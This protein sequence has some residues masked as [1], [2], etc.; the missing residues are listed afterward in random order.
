MRNTL[1]IVMGLNIKYAWFFLFLLIIACHFSGC[2]DN[3]TENLSINSELSESDR[4]TMQKS[5]ESRLLYEKEL[6]D[7]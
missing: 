7:R 6:S 2:V 4:T 1:D 3:N 5:V